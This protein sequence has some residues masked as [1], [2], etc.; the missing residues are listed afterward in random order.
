M[1]LSKLNLAAIFVSAALSFVVGGIW[2]S[3]MLFGRLWLRETGL[4]DEELKKR[5]MAAVFGT[6]F[7]LSLVIALNLAA[8]LAGPPDL[9]WG[10]AAGALA[11]IGWVATAMGITYLFEKRSMK[12]FLINAGYHA[13]TFMLMGGI[14]GVWK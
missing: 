2:Y 5:N 13:A 11:G 6:S 4:K 10:L 14:L 9:A 8:F 7:V 1:D 12:L 3:P